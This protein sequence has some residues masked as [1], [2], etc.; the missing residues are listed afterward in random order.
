MRELPAPASRILMLRC[1][2][3][4]DD[5]QVAAIKKEAVAAIGA[6]DYARAEGLLR[7]AFD[8]ARLRCIRTAP[9]WFDSAITVRR[10]RAALAMTVATNSVPV[11]WLVIIRC[12]SATHT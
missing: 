7:R 1:S 8:A 3:A 12:M 6:G 10:R 4:D 11:F 9:G 5:P 2:S